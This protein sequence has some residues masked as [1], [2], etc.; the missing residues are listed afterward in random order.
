[1]A[2]GIYSVLSYSVKRRVQEIGIRLALGARI[3]DVLRMVIIEGMKPTLL[4]VVIGTAGALAMGHILSSL[5]Y[6]VKPTDPVTFLALGI[7]ANT[8]VFTV[9]SAALLRPLPFE[10]PEELVQVWETRTSGAFQQMEAS[11]PDFVDMRNSHVFAQLGGYSRT[12]MTLSQ[13]SGA[14]QVTVAMASTG[15]FDT[16]GV[17]P[18]LGR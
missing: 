18:V 2:I 13:P 4:G 5:I 15:F 9:L 11:Y 7:G 14:V 10:K 17:R 6:G 3:S 16:V 1:A 12:T 8:A